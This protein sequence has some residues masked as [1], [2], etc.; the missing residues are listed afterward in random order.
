[1]ERE[2][3]MKGIDNTKVKTQPIDWPDVW[4]HMNLP[5]QLA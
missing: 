2:S 5:I 4:R 1:M 3:A